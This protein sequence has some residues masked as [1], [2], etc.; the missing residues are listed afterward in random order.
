MGCGGRHGGGSSGDNEM[1]TLRKDFSYWSNFDSLLCTTFPHFYT[2]THIKWV[3]LHTGCCVSLATTITCLTY[4][5]HQNETSL[6][7]HAQSS[8]VSSNHHPILEYPYLLTM[9]AQ[10]WSLITDYNYSII[11]TTKAN[12]RLDLKTTTI[13]PSRARRGGGRIYCS[14]PLLT[15]NGVASLYASL[16][17]WTAV[18]ATSHVYTYI[19]MWKQITHSLTHTHTLTIAK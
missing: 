15:Y 7:P 16:T 19:I 8:L 13:L 10:R 2:H 5:K 17:M 9:H 6:Q 1:A 4:Q 12:V 11:E 18:N 14:L 3:M